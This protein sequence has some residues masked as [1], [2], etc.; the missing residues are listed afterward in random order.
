MRRCK[1]AWLGLL[2]LLVSNGA[3]AGFEHGSTVTGEVVPQAGARIDATLAGEPVT[4]GWEHGRLLRDGDHRRQAILVLAQNSSLDGERGSDASR[5]RPDSASGLLWGLYLARYFGSVGAELG[6]TSSFPAQKGSDI[7]P[8]ANVLGASMYWRRPFPNLLSLGLGMTFG[9][10]LGDTLARGLGVDLH[11]PYGVADTYL[12]Y[13]MSWRFNPYLSYQMTRV[14]MNAAPIDLAFLVGLHLSGMNLQ[15]I[16]D[17]SG[18]GGMR[19][20]LSERRTL[21]GP[22]L[23]AG[24]FYRMANDMLLVNVLLMFDYVAAQSMEFQ[25]SVFGLDYAMRAQAAWLPV[26]MLNLVRPF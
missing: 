12:G 13:E 4:R 22:S 26:F 15:A 25:T 7:R 9:F 21:W 20:S 3:W 10:A 23:G 14:G 17:E 18:G 16:T 6:Q 1:T 24:L 19:N 5:A 11:P 8:A 2:A